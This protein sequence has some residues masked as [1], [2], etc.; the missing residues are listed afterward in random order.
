MR[1]KVIGYDKAA[2]LYVVKDANAAI[3]GLK[4]EKLRKVCMM[5]LT[6]TWQEVPEGAMVPSGVEVNMDLATGKRLVRKMPEEERVGPSALANT[7]GQFNS[8]SNEPEI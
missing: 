5:E 6:D 7:K 1:A 3:W 8:Q 4:T 2:N